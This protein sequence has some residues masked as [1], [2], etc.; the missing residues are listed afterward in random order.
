MMF[1]RFLIAIVVLAGFSSPAFAIDIQ[2]VK[3]KGGITAWLVEEHSLPIVTVSAA[4]R[5]GSAMDPAAKAGLA[6]MVSGLLD[7]GAGDL[8]SEQFQSR[9]ADKAIRMSFSA[10]RDTFGARLRTLSENSAEAFDLL[11]Q[12][13]TK[14]RFDEEAVER[15]RSQ[16][17]V[18]IKYSER[19]PQTIMAR[20]WRK[21]YF[22]DH[23]Y[24][25]ESDGTVESVKAITRDDLKTF[26]KERFAKDN[27]FVAVVGDVTADQLKGLLDKTFGDLPKKSVPYIMPPVTPP[28]EGKVIRVDKDVPQAVVEFGEQGLLRKD[29]QWYAAYVMNY[30]LGGGGFS[31]RLMDV[32]REKNG[33]VY[34]VGTGLSP[35]DYAGIFAGFFATERNTADKAMDLVEK[36]V[37]RMAKDGATQ[38]ELDAAKSYL[39]GSYPL[40]FDTSGKIAGQLLGV[41]MEG[42]GLDYID[43]RN[44]LI[45]GVTLKQVN[46]AAKRILQPDKMIWV[47]VGGAD[48]GKGS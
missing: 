24:G 17:I 5:G 47:I 13:L 38:K 32:V 28:A 18:G 20:T 10:G 14:P 23:P 9:L 27:L 22:G 30:I 40:N 45:E 48:K 44:A 6:N 37:A 29:P 25:R 46:D 16:I 34:T 19:D 36:Q 42:L 8:T 7:E 11:S 21:A 35:L 41:Q 43:K 15:I 31:S 4:F 26:V 1:R 12:A 3:S 33:L 39:T 2:V